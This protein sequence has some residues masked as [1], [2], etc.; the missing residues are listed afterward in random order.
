MYKLHFPVSWFWDDT[1]NS[2]NLWTNG[3]II[4]TL[5]KWL[6]MNIEDCTTSIAYVF[7]SDVINLHSLVLINGFR[8]A[9]FVCTVG[10]TVSEVPM[11]M[12]FSEL[13]LNFP[14]APRLGC[15]FRFHPWTPSVF[16]IRI[17]LSDFLYIRWQT[18][19]TVSC[20]LDDRLVR[21]FPAH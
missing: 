16:R 19:Q 4:I 9:Y 6:W 13:L 14:F 1:N 8:A 20:T 7:C 3:N 5:V 15:G 2:T 18:G 10:N 11:Y 21:Q 17:S 12:K